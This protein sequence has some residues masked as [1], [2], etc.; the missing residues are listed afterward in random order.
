M[1]CRVLPTAVTLH[2]FRL[3]SGPQITSAGTLVPFIRRKFATVRST[4]S[5]FLAG[6]LPCVPLEN[7]A[8]SVRSA[9]PVRRSFAHTHTIPALSS[10]DRTDLLY[11]GM[12]VNDSIRARS[13][14]L[15]FATCAT[16]RTRPLG[17]PG[18]KGVNYN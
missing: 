15:L 18:P 11:G 8:K 12:F 2:G 17:R 13:V 4:F 9:K 10:R 1:V 16:R 5:P 6:R 7:R 14:L 3:A